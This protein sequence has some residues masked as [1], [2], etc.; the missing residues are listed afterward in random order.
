[1]LS[2]LHEQ[3]GSAI[4]LVAL[5]TT[6]LIGF[7][8]LT[9]DMGTLYF[10]R[11]ELSNMVDAS[12]LAGACVLPK[13]AIYGVAEA[14]NYAAT[15]GLP[16]D[17]VSYDVGS[18]GSSLTVT[19]SRR[20]NL[21]FAPILGIANQAINASATATVSAAGAATNVV[22]WAIVV[23]DNLTYGDTRI[24]KVGGGCGSSGNYG[25]LA[26]GGT[27]G[28]TYKNNIK[29]GY[30]EQL[31]VGDWV[32]TEPGN[33]VGPTDQGVSYRISQDPNATISTVNN[34][35][36]RVV[37]VPIVKTMDLTGRKPTQIVGFAAFFL[38]SS[39]KGVVTG[40]FMQIASSNVPPGGTSEYGLYNIKLTQ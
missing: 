38:Q 28:N 21:L 24:L 27:G 40:V 1:M 3:R 7:A 32:N 34:N 26:L 20:I 30:S 23:K 25:A 36:P 13:G 16:S 31:K 39:S 19:A 37:V 35:S 14:R 33:K 5:A 10:N 18:G 8:A 17:T 11:I 9:V 29:H 6:V 15:N 4:V 12:A 22:P 2:L